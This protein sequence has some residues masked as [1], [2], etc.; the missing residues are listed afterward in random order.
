M[1][2]LWGLGVWGFRQIGFKVKRL[3]KIISS[4][5]LDVWHLYGLGSEFQGL[6]MFGM[7]N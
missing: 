6:G 7:L 1:Q 2:A 5:Q 3:F 4:Q